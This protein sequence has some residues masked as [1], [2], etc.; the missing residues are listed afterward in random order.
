MGSRHHPAVAPRLPESGA[1][2]E[3]L[4]DLGT[5]EHLFVSKPGVTDL[6]KAD[7]RFMAT[8]S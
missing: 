2:L 7:S 5:A 3:D 1:S 8:E 6:F 4:V